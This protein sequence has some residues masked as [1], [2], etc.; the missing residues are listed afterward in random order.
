M[1]GKETYYLAIP[2]IV[3][4]RFVEM[5]KDKPDTWSQLFELDPKRIFS[6]TE[7][8]SYGEMESNGSVVVDLEKLYR[9]GK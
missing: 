4:R 8:E 1:N 7:L 3:L 5:N 6:K 9:G 2:L